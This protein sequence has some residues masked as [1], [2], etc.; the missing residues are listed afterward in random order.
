MRLWKN[1]E[2]QEIGVLMS[3][4]EVSKS[5]AALN[6]A[7][8]FKFDESDPF[9]VT[10]E[11][12]IQELEWS[13]D[14]WEN[15]K[16]FP[17][18][19]AK[20]AMLCN[21]AEI[22]GINFALL[23]YRT[24]KSRGFQIRED[25]GILLGQVAESAHKFERERWELAMA[26]SHSS[27][28]HKINYYKKLV[29]TLMATLTKRK[30]TGRLHH[31]LH[32]LVKSELGREKFARLLTEASELADYERSISHW[33]NAVNPSDKHVCI[34]GHLSD[35]HDYDGV[36]RPCKSCGW[37][38]CDDFTSKEDIRDIFQKSRESTKK[39]ILE[40]EK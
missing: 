40:A 12:Q 22:E 21:E 15:D 38:K 18:N 37:G 1:K 2:N 35:R 11:R 23:T 13:N 33:Q 19:I 26:H 16:S 17:P 36:C 7:R 24:V 32:E 8:L 31:N 3:E 25:P 28:Q 4:K 30:E 20:A 29:G 5:Q 34:C 9:E 14:S 10:L 39:K 27:F 6:A